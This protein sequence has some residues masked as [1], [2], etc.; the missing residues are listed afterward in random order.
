MPYPPRNSA[1]EPRPL[2]SPFLSFPPKSHAQP[3]SLPVGPLVGRR[4]TRQSSGA[5]LWLEPS[6]SGPTPELARYSERERTHLY[7]ERPVSLSLSLFLFPSTVHL[8]LTLWRVLP[9]SLS[10]HGGAFAR[11]STR[12]ALFLFLLFRDPRTL[13]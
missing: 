11:E 10:C 7:Q 9:S 2:L 6:S 3:L 4:R 12:A 5:T 1:A 8:H 13:D